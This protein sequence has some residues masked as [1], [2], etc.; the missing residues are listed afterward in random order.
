MSPTIPI[1]G[2]ESYAFRFYSSDILEP[3][4]VHVSR[5]RKKAKIWLRTLKVE[6]NHG[7]RQPELNKV[8]KLVRDNRAVLMEAWNEYFGQD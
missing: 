1:R 5:G 6:W 3:P 2:A 8:L 7:Y 4:H